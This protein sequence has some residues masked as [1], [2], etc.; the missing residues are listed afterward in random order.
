MGT[1]IPTKPNI[2][3]TSTCIGHGRWKPSGHHAVIH[4]ARQ[5][6]YMCTLVGVAALCLVWPVYG[7]RWHV[8][9]YVY[10]VLSLDYA[11]QED[12]R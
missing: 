2:K 8:C 1:P 10:T 3:C 11:D 7:R 5:T 6:A 4:A 9:M 12:R